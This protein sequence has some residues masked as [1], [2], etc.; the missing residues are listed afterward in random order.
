MHQN[1]MIASSLLVPSG[2]S[3]FYSAGKKKDSFKKRME[4]TL[5]FRIEGTPQRLNHSSV[6]ERSIEI[7]QKLEQSFTSKPTERSLVSDIA[8]FKLEEEDP[9]FQESSR[10]VSGI[11]NATR[12]LYGAQDRN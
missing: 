7:I 11:S 8:P 10:R 5:N 4:G 2:F 1:D 9:Y 6:R 3:I 12:E